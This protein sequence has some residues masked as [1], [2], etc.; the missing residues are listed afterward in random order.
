MA[1]WSEQPITDTNVDGT[2]VV[3]R[4][5]FVASFYAE[6]GMVKCAAPAFDAWYAMLPTGAVT[7]YGSGNSRRLSK[8]DNAKAQAKV[9]AA[10]SPKSI[11][12]AFQWYHA[13]DGAK[14]GPADECCGHSFEIFVAPEGSSHVFVTFPLDFADAKKADAAVAWFA[15][16]CAMLGATHAEAGF[17]YELAWFGERAQVAYPRILATG[18]RYHGVRLWHRTTARF[19]D[20]DGHTLDTVAWLTYLDATAIA[21]LGPGA[22]EGIDVGV[23]RHK[24]AKGVLLQA[25]KLPDACDVNRP[26][27]AHALLR[28][29]NAATKPIRTPKWWVNGFAGDPDKENH[30]LGRMDP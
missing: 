17:G 21:R 20:D 9:R 24:Q 6:T 25:G 2:I 12:A 4:P 10:L 14:D 19:R 28:S 27:P 8:L 3:A 1:T 26:G 11:D 7:Y 5:A 29:V 22:I 23:T 15:Q 16:W 18:L 30:W 13:K